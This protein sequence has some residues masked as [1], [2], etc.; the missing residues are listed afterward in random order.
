[1]DGLANVDESTHPSGQLGLG[2]WLPTPDKVGSMY[3][4]LHFAGTEAAG[5]ELADEVLRV[6]PSQ[7][8]PAE[9]PPVRA[10]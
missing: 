4:Y 9:H 8:K 7:G 3:R 5:P 2:T 10:P 6:T 1:M